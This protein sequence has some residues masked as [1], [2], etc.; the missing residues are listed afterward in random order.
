MTTEIITFNYDGVEIP[1]E[2]MRKKVKHL[3]LRVLPGGRVLLSAPLLYS[4]ER[5][6]AFLTENRE[7]I[8]KHH[9]KRGARVGYIEMPFLNGDGTVCYLGVT[10][11]FRAFPALHDEVL[12]FPDEIIVRYKGKP[13]RIEKVYMEYLTAAA[14]EFFTRRMQHFLPPFTRRGVSRPT[15]KVK[16]YR[17][18]WGICFPT[19]GEI[20]INLHLMKADP[21]YIDYVIL[22]EMTHLLYHGHG[23]D[24]YAFLLHV[25]PDAR[26]RKKRLNEGVPLRGSV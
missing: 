17:S 12:V 19:R 13:S 4:G 2:L 26:E 3:R 23:N 16:R 20:V 14:T 25:L 8:R 18:K 10:R 1:V 24:F 6:D 22:H 5:I 11:R 7:W 21:S 15:V 9:E